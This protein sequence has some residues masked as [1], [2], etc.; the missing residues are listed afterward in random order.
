MRGEYVGHREITMPEVLKERR[1]VLGRSPAVGQ[2]SVV[3]GLLRFGHSCHSGLIAAGPQHG[4]QVRTML[5]F[6][7]PCIGVGREAVSRG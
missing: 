5:L 1:E 6:W 2:R 7:I 4:S 3:V